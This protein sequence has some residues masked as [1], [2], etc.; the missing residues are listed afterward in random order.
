MTMTKKEE[1][2]LGIIK[3]DLIGI[4]KT[5]KDQEKQIKEIRKNGMDSEIHPAYHIDIQTGLSYTSGYCTGHIKLSED[6]IE[7]LGMTDK[8]I[9]KLISENKKISAKNKKYLAAV[10]KEVT[11]S[12]K[13]KSKKHNDKKKKGKK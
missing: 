10:F 12:V 11:E 5:L 9:E 4:K 7:L 2:I 3:K 1:L 8:E 6:V 13:V